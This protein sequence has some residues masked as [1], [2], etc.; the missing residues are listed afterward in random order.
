[1]DAPSRR[2][3]LS[4]IAKSSD[5]A[6]AIERFHIALREAQRVFE[7][8]GEN[9][10]RAGAIRAVEA[11]LNLIGDLYS[12]TNEALQAPILALIN[13]LCSLEENKVTP[14]L[15]P[16][17]RPGRPSDTALREALK[18]TV[19]WSAKK[20]CQLGHNPRTAYDIIAKAL[21]DEKIDYL[22]RSITH[23]TIREWCEAVAAD[24]G[25]HGIAA[26]VFAT[27][28][29]DPDQV[30]VPIGADNKT[31]IQRAILRPL[32]ELARKT[33]GLAE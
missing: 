16:T 14:L 8:K 11:T 20:L 30:M 2:R 23:R 17:P 4:N 13:A 28:E 26:R 6:A 15:T 32:V 21:N 5:T 22:P 9:D 33:R 10:G 24:F 27:M 19:A 25:Q 12:V 1:M 29:A 31:V 3:A 7:G 18:G